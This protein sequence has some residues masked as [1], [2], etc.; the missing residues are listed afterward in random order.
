MAEQEDQHRR[1]FYLKGRAEPQRYRLPSGR[2]RD[3]SHVPVRNRHEHGGALQRQLEMLRKLEV[4]RQFEAPRQFETPPSSLME[5][6]EMH[7]MW[8]TLG[9]EERLGLQVEF[10]SSSNT[11]LTIESL[12]RERSGIEL[13]NVRHEV[14][15]TLA[16]V[17]VPDGKL[18][19]FENLINA[20]LDESKDTTTGPRNHNFLNRISE[21]RAATLHS[22]WT[23]D[24]KEFPE[25]D[26]EYIWWEV[27][28]EKRRNLAQLVYGTNYIAEYDLWR[29][30]LPGGLWFP[31][32]IVLLAYCPAWRMKQWLPILNSIAELRRGKEVVEFFDSLPLEEQLAWSEDLTDRLNQS[33]PDAS[34]PHICLLDTGVN[35]S[36]PLLSPALDRRDLHSVESAWGA[37]DRDGHG[38][39]MAGLAL[40]GNLTQALASPQN[41]NI[42]HR[43]ES[44]KIISSSRVANAKPNYGN[45]MIDAV[46]SSEIAASQR[47]RV[48]SMAVAAFNSGS[49][50]RPSSWSSTIDSLAS[51]AVND[52]LTPRLFVISAGNV[53]NQNAWMEY[54]N[55]NSSDSI[56]DPGQSWNALTVG[57]ST[58]L[59]SITEP[60]SS[61]LAPIAPAGGLSPY[62]TTSVTWRPDSPL[63]PDVLF[64]GGNAAKSRVGARTMSSLSLLTTRSDFQNRLFTTTNA[65]SAASTLAAQMAAQ[66]MVEYPLYWPETIRALIVHSAQWT[67]AMRQMFLPSGTRQ[68]QDDMV[69]LVRHC[70]FGIPDIDRATW[71]V[72]NSLIVVSEDQLHSFGQQGK[73]GLTFGYMNLHQLP[74]PV[75]ELKAI[76]KAQVEMRVTLSYFIEPN[77]SARGN[78]RRYPYRSHGLHF[79]VKRSFESERDFCNRV[80]KEARTN[81]RKSKADK[82]PRWLIG[83]QNRHKGSI[84]S[85]IWRGDAEDLASQGKI[86]VYYV[87]GWW[88]N[89]QHLGKANQTARY[90]LVVSIYPLN[91]NVD[92]YS[93]I[94]R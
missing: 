94:A 22:F 67:P 86:A 31:E 42:G 69:K 65:T 23:D 9:L 36:H 48:F 28:L 29:Y 88:R 38:T 57:A 70:G 80:A 32:R 72:E 85:D 3:R 18:K 87:P 92:L 46:S 26:D 81:K 58:D 8:E 44:V 4:S 60:N 71:C 10:K 39:E 73:A 37:N 79:D 93:S 40:F 11:E 5:V 76:G 12:A 90:A 49:R 64:E 68:T 14:E 66:L 63:K 47:R 45:R 82:N 41:I 91:S 13:L 84:H 21:I 51:D 61:G 54:P 56:L 62:S 6:R 50:G 33:V 75:E 43:L 59:V 35:N 1:H 20:Y 74:W 34:V 55:S 78:S 53:W 2:Y 52:G 77:P 15:H 19:I 25:S 17:F 30:S 83:K 24:P 16:T 89:R 27:W 7:G